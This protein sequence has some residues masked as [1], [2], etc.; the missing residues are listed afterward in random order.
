MITKERLE[1]LIEQGATIWHDDFGEIK[2][3]KNTCEVCDVKGWST[4]KH[5]YWALY[6]EYKYN[7]EKYHHDI[8]IDDLEEDVENGREQ[9]EFGNIT[10]TERLELPSWG[11]FLKQ[12]TVFIFK[13]KTSQI[14]SLFKDENT[15]YIED[16]NWNIL[17]ES[18]T[19]ENYNEARRLC[20]KLF[21]GEEV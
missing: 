17:R 19:R 10:R 5:I 9:L 21:K 16:E 12:E 4:G 18:L 11:E 2:L 20:V 8:N 6:F 15:I 14:I 13:S 3:N 1:Q 7:N